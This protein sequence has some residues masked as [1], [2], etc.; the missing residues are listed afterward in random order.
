MLPQKLQPGPLAGEISFFAPIS[1]FFFIVV[2]LVITLVKRVDL[3]PM[4]FFF[5]SAAFFSFHLLLAYLVDHIS[6][7]LAFVIA[8]AVSLILVTISFFVIISPFCLCKSLYVFF[9]DK[10]EFVKIFYAYFFTQKPP[11]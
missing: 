1:L 4:H 2:M 7:H 9:Q 8:S 11:L 5:L 10:C 3:H 6:I